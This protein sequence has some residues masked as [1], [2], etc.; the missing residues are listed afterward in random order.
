MFPFSLFP[1]NCSWRTAKTCFC[2]WFSLGYKSHL[3]IHHCNA[4]ECG[5]LWPQYILCET[6]PNGLKVWYDS[7]TNESR[8]CGIR[9]SHMFFHTVIYFLKWPTNSLRKLKDNFFFMVPHQH[10]N[11]HLFFEESFLET[12]SLLL[13]ALP[14]ILAPCRRL[15][16]FYWLT[17]LTALYNRFTSSCSAEWRNLRWTWWAFACR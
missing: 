5:S 16:W 12:N 3:W 7:P 14:N 13:S 8:I 6:D 17:S 1:Q 9:L 4:W 11:P 15:C 10:L 2:T